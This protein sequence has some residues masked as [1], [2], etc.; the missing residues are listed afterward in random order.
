MLSNILK[1]AYLFSNNYIEV[2]GLVRRRKRSWFNPFY[3]L[4][5]LETR[6]LLSGT[7]IDESAGEYRVSTF[8]NDTGVYEYQLFHRGRQFGV[9]LETPAG[10]IGFRGRVDSYEVDGFGPTQQFNPFLNDADAVMRQIDSV[11]VTSAGFSAA[12]SG[13]IATQGGAASAGSWISMF[14]ISYNLNAQQAT[15]NGQ[16]TVSLDEFLNGKDLN[17][18][19]L[20]S[21]YVHQVQL[22]T[23]AIGNS[24]DMR[25]MEVLYGT[26]SQPPDFT[27]VP[28]P[29]TP[30]T[31]PTDQSAQITMIIHGEINL[32]DPNR[33]AI[34]KP[35]I[36]HQVTLSAGQMTAGGFWTEAKN[37]F[38][39]DNFRGSHLV[40]AD[41]MTGNN[42]S[43]YF[44]TIW[45][46][47]QDTFQT[48][49]KLVLIEQESGDTVNGQAT[50]YPL[51]FTSGPTWLATDARFQ[52]GDFNGDG[53]DDILAINISSGAVRVSLSG[54]AAASTWTTSTDSVEANDLLVGDFDG[55]GL[56]DFTFRRADGRWIIE[57]STG[58]SFTEV[59]GPRW[60]IS[61]WRDGQ[62]LVGDFNADGKEDIALRQTIGQWYINYGTSTGFDTQYAGRW[63]ESTYSW[64]TV[65]AGDFNGDGRTDIAGRMNAGAWFILQMPTGNRFSMRY[66]GN[67]GTSLNWNDISVGDFTGDGIDDLIGWENRGNFW[68][69]VGGAA[70]TLQLTHFGRWSPTRSWTTVVA[71]INGDAEDDIIGFSNGQWWGLISGGSRFDPTLFL[72]VTSFTNNVYLFSARI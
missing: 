12:I 21:N 6:V 34:R 67:W 42:F 16:T 30:G 31:F 52:T 54:N 28:T 37:D 13:A 25:S 14:T 57:R 72:G 23:G 20:A 40:H 29:A 32:S 50:D 9:L 10:T 2:L 8:L 49:D 59:N 4:E 70:G 3:Q 64:T 17:L 11:T 60:A 36:R 61:G 33:I 27:F 47:P 44:E 56:D 41:G 55:D 63:N 38:S 58:D 15:L 53:S 24:G 68:V 43:Y 71:D 65:V 19:G 45:E 69:L 1:R 48:P 62:A 7:P 26:Q 46:V 39:Q 18:G 22:N 66:A 5:S 51:T 35:T